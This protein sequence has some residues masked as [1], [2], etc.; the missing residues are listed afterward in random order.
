MLDVL[1]PTWDSLV[2]IQYAITHL[3]DLQLKYVKG[4]QVD[5]TPYARLPLLAH[6]NV[7]ADSLAGN[8]QDQHG[9][10][11]PLVLWTPRTHALPHL[12]E[13]TVTSSFTAALC[14]AC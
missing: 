13:G 14:H 9:Q 12:V 11:C 2:E 10:D 6:L 3:T 5:K 1:C 4:H 8:F 7:D